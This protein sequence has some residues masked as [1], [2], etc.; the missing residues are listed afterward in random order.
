[1]K[2]QLIVQ[3]KLNTCGISSEGTSY[4]MKNAFACIMFEV[5]DSVF[6]F[7]LQPEDYKLFRQRYWLA[8]METRSGNSYNFIAIGSGALPGD[9]IAADIFRQVSQPPNWP[10]SG[11]TSSKT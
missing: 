4:D 3:H 9:K 1:M 10:G 5:I 7:L 11:K 8:S 2:Q 6:G